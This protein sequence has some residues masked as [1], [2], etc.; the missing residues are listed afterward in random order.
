MMN[1]TTIKETG[2]ANAGNRTVIKGGKQPARVVVD[3]NLEIGENLLAL[4]V[5]YAGGL[6]IKGV[7]SGIIFA[8][9]AVCKKITSAKKVEAKAYTKESK[10]ED[11]VESAED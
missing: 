9:K 1:R 8:G 11:S 5:L 10:V 2:R 3:H 4:G 6:A 7:V